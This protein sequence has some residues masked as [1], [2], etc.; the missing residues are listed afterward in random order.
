MLQHRT[1]LAALSL[2]LVVSV[3]TA[4]GAPQSVDL[5]LKGTPG[6]ANRYVDTVDF[7]MDF[8]VQPPGG[9]GLAI[10][11]TPRFAGTF[12]TVQE[13]RG[14][15]PNGDL[16]LGL[17]IESFD[18]TLD[19][20]DL[21]VRLAICGPNGAPPTLIKLPPLPVEMVLSKRGKPVAISGL[22]QLP[23]PPIPG[24]DGK[25][26]DLVKIVGK[27]IN[28]F[29]QPL[30][31]DKL[32][33]VGDKWEWQMV[34]DPVA[35]M[36]SFG[37]PMPPE[38]AAQMS[39]FKIPIKNTSTLVGFETVGGVECARIEAVAPWQLEMPAGPPGQGSFVLKEQ[40][41]TLVTTWLDYAAGRMVKQNTRVEVTM[42]VSDGKTTPVSMTMTG[43]AVSELK[44]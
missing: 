16:S 37:M 8:Q 39:S 30:Y 28:Q 42:T 7:S 43:T 17:Q 13:V 3:V 14:V 41:K 23:I 24:P 36:E 12:T 35:M 11:V 18:A 6:E 29:S 33:G 26:I 27:F 40:G 32:V 22:E 10:A 19:A 34:I 20:A 2:L 31:P 15:A 4:W 21:H 44:P 1:T 25:P 38:A 9:A 5:A